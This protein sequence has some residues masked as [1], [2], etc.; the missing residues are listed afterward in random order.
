MHV[1]IIEPG[2]PTL[3]SD[4]PLATQLRSHRISAEQKAEFKR[5]RLEFGATEEEINATL[6]LV[7]LHNADE[8]AV[9]KQREVLQQQLRDATRTVLM[10][11]VGASAIKAGEQHRESQA[12]NAL[13]QF[14][15]S[16][17]E[18]LDRSSPQFFFFT[19]TS[20]E[21]GQVGLLKKVFS[22]IHRIGES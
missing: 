16:V 20:P 18:Q 4:I 22:W 9:A 2:F 1:E 7:D 13:I 8:M 12:R 5:V 15:A 10:K 3:S 17:P 19:H 11:I 21:S 14:E 6:Q